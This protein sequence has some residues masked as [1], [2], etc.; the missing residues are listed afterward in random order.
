MDADAERYRSTLEQLAAMSGEKSSSSE[1]NRLV[2]ENHAS[3]LVL[4]ESDEGR[5]AIEKLMTHDSATVRSFAAAHVLLWNEAAARPVLEM[6]ATSDTAL[7]AKCTLRE[8]DR[9]RLSH[10]W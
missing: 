9:G 7:D 3:Y 6:L 1:W 2:R 8:Y 10:D 5:S 4:R